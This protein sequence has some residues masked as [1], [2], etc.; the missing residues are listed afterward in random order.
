MLVFVCVENVFQILFLTSEV[1]LLGCAPIA[2]HA[3][4]QV[5][6]LRDSLVDS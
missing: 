3:P 5:T 4:P 2:F 6:S 1:S